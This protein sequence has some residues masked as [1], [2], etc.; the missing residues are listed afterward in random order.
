MV[1][2]FVNGGIRVV[3]TFIEVKELIVVELV[4]VEFVVV[5]GAGSV[6]FVEITTVVFSTRRVV[7]EGARV[8]IISVVV[9]GSKQ[10]SGDDHSPFGWHVVLSV[11]FGGD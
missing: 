4:T 11:T 10:F 7:K 3:L 8:V 6:V 9:D 2:A 1:D 5:V